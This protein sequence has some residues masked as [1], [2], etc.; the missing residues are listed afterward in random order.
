MSAKPTLKVV[1]DALEAK[2]KRKDF[3]KP[4][5]EEDLVEYTEIM[6]GSL[7]DIPQSK[8]DFTTL[9]LTEEAERHLKLGQLLD[10]FLRDLSETD[11]FLKSQ[12]YSMQSEIKSSVNALADQKQEEEIS[13]MALGVIFREF[14]ERIFDVDRKFVDGD[15]PKSAYNLRGYSLE[16]LEALRLALGK[17][18]N[19]GQKLLLTPEGLSPD[20]IPLPAGLEALVI[21]MGEVQA[22]RKSS[23]FAPNAGEQN[24]VRHSVRA[25]AAAALHVLIEDRLAPVDFAARY[26]SC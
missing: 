21:K 12:K 23:F 19:A 17:A 18:D 5:T 14:L 15:R 24:K 16:I 3:N 20:G 9:T 2:T 13:L 11:G 26:V 1:W 7:R 10:K 22:G 25:A 8:Y 6:L 4:L